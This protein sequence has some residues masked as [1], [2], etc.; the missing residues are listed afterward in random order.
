MVRFLPAPFT[1]AWLALT[2]MATWLLC[3]TD[4]LGGFAPLFFHRRRSAPTS[5]LPHHLL[6]IQL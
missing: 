6:H 4:A 5:T 1:A 2:S 3:E